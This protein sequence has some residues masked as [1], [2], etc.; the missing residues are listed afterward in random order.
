M[1]YHYYV[2]LA[3]DKGFKLFKAFSKLRIHYRNE[4]G[5]TDLA[6]RYFNQAVF[7]LLPRRATQTHEEAACLGANRIPLTTRNFKR[8]LFQN[9]CGKSSIFRH[10]LPA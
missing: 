4:G 8:T 3:P 7:T 5:K 9:A 6:R 2:Q 10:L 1:P